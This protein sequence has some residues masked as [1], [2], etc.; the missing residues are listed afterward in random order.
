MECEAQ[1][2][3]PYLRKDIGCLEKIQQRATKL[4]PQSRNLDYEDRLKALNLT[5]LGERRAR[6]DLIQAYRIITGM[7]M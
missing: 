5:T 6:R 3:H 2:W 4:V 7:I 1:A